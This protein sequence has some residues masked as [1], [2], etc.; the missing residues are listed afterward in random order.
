M[1]P[2]RWKFVGTG[3][4]LIVLVL[5][6]LF[7]WPGWAHS[8]T[9]PVE[10]P[11]PYP[12]QPTPSPYPPQLTL[13][14]YPTAVPVVATEVPSVPASTAII[15]FD[16]LFKWNNGQPH[17]GLPTGPNDNTT[18][19]LHGDLFGE[20]KPTGCYWVTVTNT[21]EIGQFYPGTYRVIGIQGGSLEDRLAV[22]ADRIANLGTPCVQR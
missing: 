15:V 13:T 9:A 16:Q 5:F 7:V 18:W 17:Q 8:Q 2:R 1:T 3:A 6:G 12:P 14:P 19:L 11:T 10:E 20:S 22:A 4:G 21:N